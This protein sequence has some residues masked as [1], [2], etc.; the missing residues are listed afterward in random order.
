MIR[1]ISKECSCNMEMSEK[2]LAKF[3]DLLLDTY[4]EFQK[5]CEKHGIIFY[6]CCG[7]AIGVV[8]HKG[9][10][11]WD[12]D[13]DVY[14]KREDY[15]RF[16]S[17]KNELENTD[18]EILDINNKG[19]YST[20]AKFSSKKTSIWEMEI[21]PIVFGVYID[22][23]PLELMWGSFED[24]ANRKNDYKKWSDRYMLCTIKRPWRDI[25]KAFLN[26]NIKQTVWYTLE[27]LLFPLCRGIVKSRLRNIRQ[28][29]LNAKNS[30]YVE[31][32]GSL[33][34]KQIF[35]KECFDSVIMMPFEG[36][37]MPMPVGYDRML[38]IQYGDYM[39][40]PPKEQQI[41][42]HVH[43]FYDLDKRV[44][45]DEARKILKGRSK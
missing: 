18:Y 36:V 45:I 31:I 38:T 16:V 28:Y 14:M 25:W 43:H 23:F 37:E 26:K 21:E 27:K 24:V 42:H 32:T 5:F 22:V 29:R 35:P 30:Y 12:D 39:K 6:A 9:F 10:I 13:I 11:P 33:A 19:Y 17:L 15:D 2:D 1:G 4:V 34:E 8:R 44:S 7:T 20:F 41:S 40:L 3:K